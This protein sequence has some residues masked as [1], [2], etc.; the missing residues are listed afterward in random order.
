MIERSLAEEIVGCP[1]KVVGAGGPALQTLA[2][3]QKPGRLERLRGKT[4]DYALL[5]KFRLSLLVVFTALA[6]FALG[7]LE[8]IDFGKMLLF[9]LGN[10]LVVA[11][12]NA[13]NQV[14][15]RDYD[16]LM[17]RTANRPLPAGRMAA[18]EA[19]AGG[20]MMALAGLL[21]LLLTANLL[22]VL[23]AALALANYVLIYTPLK[24]KSSANTMVGAASGAI[25]PV[26]GWAAVRDQI[27]PQAVA[28]FLILFF[29]QFPHFLAIA[30]TYRE[31]YA[32]AG[33]RMLP[34]VDPTGRRAGRQAFFFSLLLL[35][36]SLL[37][38]FIGSEGP[39]YFCGALALGGA[40]LA[41]SFGLW[42]ARTGRAARRLMFSAMVYLPALLA[43]MILD[44]LS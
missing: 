2:G 28:L 19:A 31:D 29:W 25:P 24:R 10:F 12:A 26:M 34:V 42:A 33:F 5:V 20:A 6:G 4:A 15:E 27:D 8:R 1:A 30:W 13:L 32:R 17:Q 39:A 35:V 21:L 40:L 23:L 18:K 11:G 44:R 16:A 22:T 41:G 38:Y 3:A 36:A 37:P 7:S 43:L 14:I 9:G